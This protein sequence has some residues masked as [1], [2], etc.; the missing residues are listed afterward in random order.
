[1]SVPWGL[2]TV[3]ARRA[4]FIIKLSIGIGIGHNVQGKNMGLVGGDL[5]QY[6][7]LFRSTF[8]CHCTYAATRRVLEPIDCE[9]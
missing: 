2:T 5:R 1:M 3:I 4:S 9:Y 6:N 7:K 8:F